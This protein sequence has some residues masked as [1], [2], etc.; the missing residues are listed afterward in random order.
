MDMTHIDWYI[1]DE[2]DLRDRDLSERNLAGA[3]FI[4]PPLSQ[5]SRRF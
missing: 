5:P 1:F 2:C 3:H 4:V